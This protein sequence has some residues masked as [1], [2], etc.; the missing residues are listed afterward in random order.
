MRSTRAPRA[1]RARRLELRRHLRL[2]AL[3]LPRT[4]CRPSPAPLRVQAHLHPPPGRLLRRVVVGTVG[5][6]G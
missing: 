6:V 4:L 1:P 5:V 2:Q 3:R